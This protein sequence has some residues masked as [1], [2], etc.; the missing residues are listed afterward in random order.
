MYVENVDFNKVQ[1]DLVLGMYNYLRPMSLYQHD[2]TFNLIGL[3]PSTITSL[4][5]T[6]KFSKGKILIDSIISNSGAFNAQLRNKDQIIGIDNNKLNEVYYYSDFYNL[7]LG[8]ENSTSNLIIIREKD[9]ININ[10]KRLKIPNHSIIPIPN[11]LNVNSINSY[12]KGLE[13][14]DLIFPDTISKSRSNVRT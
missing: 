7:S 12:E 11:S 10:V 5:M 14:F 13:L 6:V 3:K 2:S 9:T 4:G 8:T 1:N